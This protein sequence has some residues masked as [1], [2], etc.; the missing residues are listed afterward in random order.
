MNAND[1]EMNAILLKVKWKYNE[2]RYEKKK[3]GNKEGGWN[4]VK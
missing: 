4:E 1:M 3:P 2:K